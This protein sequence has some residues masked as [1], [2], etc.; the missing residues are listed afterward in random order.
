MTHE[1]PEKGSRILVVDDDDVFRER[2]LRA[3][4]DRG[5]V[6]GGAACFDDALSIVDRF[7]PSHAVIDLRMPG[8]SG[9][10]LVAALN[11]RDPSCRLVVLTGYGSIATAIEAIRIGA[12]HYLTKPAEVDE[13]LAA[14]YPRAPRDA[15]PDDTELTPPSL[16]RMEWEHIQR[17]LNDCNGNISQAARVLGIH[18][19]S[20][21]RKLA[22]YPAKR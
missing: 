19:R 6:T 15:T 16:A 13:I 22:K 8:R 12:T 4:N 10:D 21:Q 17:V 14:F 2:L 11:T 20:L 1:F 5:Y 7:A 3:L 9:L 18:R